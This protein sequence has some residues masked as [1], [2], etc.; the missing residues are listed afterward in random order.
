MSQR[1]DA[2][3]HQRRQV[4]RIGVVV[5]VLE[6]GI[7]RYGSRVYH[8]DPR[9]SCPSFSCNPQAELREFAWP[10]AAC[11]NTGLTRISSPANRPN[12][13]DFVLWPANQSGR[14]LNFT[15]SPQQGKPA[16][17]SAERA[18]A[19]WESVDAALS[20]I[21]GHNG[22]AALFYRCAHLGSTDHPWL[23]RIQATQ[24]RGSGIA[25]PLLRSVL[26]QQ[27][28]PE[29]AVA[30]RMLLGKF[31][32]QLAILIGESLT[33]RLL[34]SIWSDIF[35]DEPMQDAPP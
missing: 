12:R 31:R 7:L 10:K 16:T 3:A 33:E 15:P 1:Q 17:G 9:F 19:A 11:G 35:S 8:S 4:T 27:P 24:P 32:E 21:I 18:V 30:N 34:S 28:E 29:V 14:V 5:T 26:A 25:I 2:Q 20:P 22:V 6:S 23:A 13:S